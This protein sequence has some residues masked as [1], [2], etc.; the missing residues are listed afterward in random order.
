M[1]VVDFIYPSDANFLLVKAK[2]SEE[3]FKYLINKQIITRNRSKVALCEGC[4]RITVGTEME[5]RSLLEAISE[6]EEEFL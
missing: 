1:K 2:K 4:I 5:N 6:F 3:L